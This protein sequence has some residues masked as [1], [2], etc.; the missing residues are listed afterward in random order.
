MIRDGHA[1]GAATLYLAAWLGL[2]RPEEQPLI[3]MLDGWGAQQA[4][5]RQSPGT[6]VARRRTVGA[7]AAHAEAFPWSW[8]A[9]LADECFT[10]M[11]AVAGCGPR[12]CAATRNPS[13]T[14]TAT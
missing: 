9:Q 1:P 7:F 4:A 13:V 5:R 2:L 3:A 6:M 14:S 11:Q 10:D 12:R 8:T